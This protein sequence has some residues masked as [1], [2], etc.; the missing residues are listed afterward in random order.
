MSSG[1]RAGLDPARGARRS[2][3]RQLAAGLALLPAARAALAV[4]DPH[5]QLSAALMASERAFARSMADRDVGAFAGFIAD[6]ALFFDGQ[7]APLR[8]KEAVVAAWRRF[9]GPGP[10]PFAWTPDEAVVAPGGALGVT[11]GPVTA[12]DGRLLARFQ[13]VWRREPDGRWRVIIDKGSEV[14][15]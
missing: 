15:R 4:E 6:D 2:A 13:T 14:C 5:P 11:S 7:G 10:A 3:L 1:R 8:G 9:F 12:P